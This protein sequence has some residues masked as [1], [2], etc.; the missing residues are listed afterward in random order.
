VLGDISVTAGSDF[1]LAGGTCAKGQ[2]L[3]AGAGCTVAL[4]FRP[5][6]A[7]TR[8]GT[9][10]VAHNGAG[11]ASTVA[12]TG[13]GGSTAPVVS[14]SPTQLT[15]SQALGSTSGGQRVVVSN[16]GEATL[17]IDSVQLTG[18]SAADYALGS[19][20]TC[21]AGTTVAVSS[22]C[23][24][25]LRF[26]PAALGARNAAV[27]LKHNAGAGLST[28][29][30]VGEGTSAPAPNMTLT[31]TR[32]DLGTQALGIAGPPRTVEIGNAG[33][34]TLSIRGITASG[35][36]A[37]DMVL[38]G[39]CAAGASVAPGG[40][41]TITVALQPAALGTRVAMLEI[42]SNTPTGT[43]SISLSGEAIAKPA[44]FVNLSPVALGFGRVTL[45]TT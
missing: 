9:L 35:P 28:V 3:A 21:T 33:A 13:L 37:A 42:T 30:L 44:P 26:S 23:V 10:S 24:L 38:G 32:L 4:S 12:L 14:L 7:G 39:S 8:S 17:V 34:A 5:T 40:T 31:A 41:C 25:D 36:H 18:D 11:G 15:F 16:T 27:A 6:L 19:G 2:T 45:G 43:A 22:T 29:A 20:T 1:A